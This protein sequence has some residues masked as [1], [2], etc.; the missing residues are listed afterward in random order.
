MITI[1][2]RINQWNGKITVG[3]GSGDMNYTICSICGKYADD[4]GLHNGEFTCHDC[5]D[6]M[7]TV[8]KKAIELWEKD[9][10]ND[11]PDIEVMLE[12]A[13]KVKR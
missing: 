1:N 4:G 2:Q 3:Q 6:Q 13:K 11:F 9:F 5:L 8:R 12:Y 10:D 7:T